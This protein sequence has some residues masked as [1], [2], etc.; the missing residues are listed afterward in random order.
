MARAM[1][2]APPQEQPN[3]APNSPPPQPIEE[4]GEEETPTESLYH[5]I[6]QALET[7]CHGDETPEDFKIRAVT[8]FS[9]MSMWPD[10]KYE[11]LSKGVQDWVFD[12]TTIHKNNTNKKRKKPLPI[13]PGLDSTETRARGRVSLSDEPKRGRTRSTGEDCLTRTMKLLV[14]NNSPEKLKAADLVDSLKDKYGKEYSTAAVRYAQ[15]AFLTA[16][17]LIEQQVAAE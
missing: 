3:P 10:E 9:D 17:E 16:R 8:D 4:P 15:Q 1:S 12:A 14:V 13:L 2:D 6:C 7:A 11:M 5:Q